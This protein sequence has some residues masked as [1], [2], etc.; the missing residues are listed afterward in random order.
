MHSLKIYAIFLTTPTTIYF[1]I[2]I[3]NEIL[4]VVTYKYFFKLFICFYDI[5]NIFKYILY[6]YLGLILIIHELF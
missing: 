2:E 6:S 5:F 3:E 4:H 1:K